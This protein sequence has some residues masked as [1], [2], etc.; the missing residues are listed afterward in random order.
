MAILTSYQ[1]DFKAKDISKDEEGHLIMKK[2]WI[3]QEYMTFLNVHAPHHS[4]SKY[5]K[6]RVMELQGEIDKP[7]IIIRDFKTTL[8]IIEGTSRQN[9]NQ[10]YRTLE[11][12]SQ[13]KGPNWHLQHTPPSSNRIYIFHIHTGHLPRRFTFWVIK[14]KTKYIY[15]IFIQKDWN[16]YMLPLFIAYNFN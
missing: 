2:G 8:S 12:F 5:M 6:Q 9:E 7:T 13:P 15:N 11:Q 3:N 14:Q 16:T 1:V 4:T 10:G